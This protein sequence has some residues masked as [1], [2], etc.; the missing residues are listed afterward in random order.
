VSTSAITSDNQQEIQNKVEE[1][2]QRFGGD[3]VAIRYD[4]DTDWVGDPA[5]HFRILLPDAVAN[6]RQR[7]TDVARRVR[8]GLVD[9]LGFAESERTPYFSF[10][11]QSEQA[12][13]KDPGW[14]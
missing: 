5:V 4:L 1:V 11:S 9:K 13:L 12:E 8:D 6:N 7:L 14:D 2:K 3:I 10:R